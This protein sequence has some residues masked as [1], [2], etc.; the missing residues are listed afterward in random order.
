MLQVNAGPLEIARVF[1]P[2][3]D[4]DSKKQDLLRTR[5]YAFVQACAAGVALN[6]KLIGPEQMLLQEEL[7]RGLQDLKRQLVELGLDE[8]KF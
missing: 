8:D 2:A 5:F 6:K 7:E 4:V 1:L 3:K